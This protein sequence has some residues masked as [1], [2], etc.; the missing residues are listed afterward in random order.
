ME[1]NTKI[2]YGPNQFSKRPCVVFSLVKF[3]IEEKEKL[4]KNYVQ[5]IDFFSTKYKFQNNIKNHHKI[6]KVLQFICDVSL[7]ILNYTRGDLSECGFNN[8]SD[9]TEFFI[10]FHEP[11]LT[12]RAVEII[13]NFIFKPKFENSSSILNQ[14]WDECRKQHPDFQ[15]HA[16]ITSAKSKNLYFAPMGNRFWLYGMGK[17]SQIFFETSTIQDMN[18]NFRTDKLSCKLYFHNLGIPTPE[19]TIVKSYLEAI[20]AVKNIGFPCVIKPIN[21]GKGKGV[22]ANIQSLE[23][24]QYAYSEAS[25]FAKGSK[26]VL[27]E[28]HVHGTDYRL[29]T[30][31]GKF[32][33]CIARQAP[34]ITGDGI[35]TVKN[36]I[37][38]Q[39]NQFRTK[40]LY[41]SHF[42]VPVKIDR[43]V[44][45]MLKAQNTKIDSIPEKGVKIILQPNDN[46]STGGTTE[47]IEHIH[48]KVI[49]DAEK[50]LNNSTLHSLGIDYITDD[51]TKS[52]TESAGNFIEINKIQA[53]ATL[54]ATGYDVG[55]AGSYFFAD[56][57][58]NI[59]ID[60]YIVQKENI[61]SFYNSYTNKN[62]LFLPNIF[63]KEGKV[64]KIKHTHFTQVIKKVLSDTTLDSLDIIVS[65]D[66]VEN[67]G[68]PTE[69]I[70]EIY[71]ERS[72]TSNKL[73]QM[74]ENNN[75]RHN[76]I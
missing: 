9:R 13:L 8:T 23:Q 33:A 34:Y 25:K 70:N 59:P 24:A 62:A 55:R 7:F 21:S 43:V 63:I 6:D 18:N 40:N 15:A 72:C 4:S 36:L 52:P 56:F 10:E 65:C 38:Q 32:I 5:C 14:F 61:E 41:D 20:A 67:Y 45:E 47:L 53:I 71:I 16:L 1:I 73:L 66:I 57:V 44:H 22:T 3:R 51:I 27:V 50:I 69:H 17:N 26:E 19:Y 37:N 28:K 75:F 76:F 58:Q 64:T 68:L 11:K 48:P 29:M 12:I 74:I 49:K 46:I 42:L 2:F 30:V 31:N 39:I 35:N 54:L 60:L